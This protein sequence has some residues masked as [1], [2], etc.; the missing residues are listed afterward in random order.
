MSNEISELNENLL[1]NPLSIINQ[2]SEISTNQ[3]LNN[4]INSDKN[5]VLKTEI[6]KPKKLALLLSLAKYLEKQGYPK[7]S[8]LLKD[9]ITD[10]LTYMISNERKSRIEVIKALTTKFEKRYNSENSLMNN[11]D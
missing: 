3:I 4:L 1:D 2:S 9:F 7:A 8:N 5:L 11:L 6:H 10:Y